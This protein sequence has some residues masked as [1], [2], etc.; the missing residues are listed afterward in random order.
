VAYATQTNS[1]GTVTLKLDIYD[2]QSFGVARLGPAVIYV[3]GG[4]W[5]MGDK[6]K[7]A[8]IG[9]DLAAHG[10]LAYLINYR[11]APCDPTQWPPN[12]C[13][14]PPP[15]SGTGL[16]TDPVDDVEAAV[17]WVL[18]NNVS[19]G[20]T[21]VVGVLGGSAGGHLADLVGLNIGGGVAPRTVVSLSGPAEVRLPTLNATDSTYPILDDYVG[22]PYFGASP[23]ACPTKY[24]TVSPVF[25][26]TKVST[27]FLQFAAP[28]D[29][30]FNYPIYSQAQSF[31]SALT[32][33]GDTNSLVAPAS[34]CH[35]AACWYVKTTNGPTVEIATVN[36]MTQA[37]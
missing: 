23:P 1:S 14:S 20:G 22:C 16:Y 5:Q 31:Q 36:W 10:F 29:T 35:G 7:N 24:E 18:K 34:T 25:R 26:A 8:F 15:L 33:F 13:T 21:Q 11:L 19:Y 2:P 28:G 9:N 37:L 12:T 4:G 32:S 6:S 3:H 30:A 17:G 27:S